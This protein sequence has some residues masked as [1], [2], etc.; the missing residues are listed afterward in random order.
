MS[1]FMVKGAAA[2]VNE[3]LGCG[4]VPDILQLEFYGLDDQE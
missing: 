1:P 3:R 4:D 2:A